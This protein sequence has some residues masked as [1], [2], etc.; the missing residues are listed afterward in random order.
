[1]RC[2]LS[3]HSLLTTHTKILSAGGLTGAGGNLSFSKMGPTGR[4]E[5]FYRVQ[6]FA[7]VLTNGKEV[8][9]SSEYVWRG[10]VSTVLC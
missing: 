2:T 8:K 10:T 4:N 1:M 5:I 3:T 7:F 6:A 9:H